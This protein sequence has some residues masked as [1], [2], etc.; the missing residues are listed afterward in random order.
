M[1]V[2]SAGKDMGKVV[3]ALQHVKARAEGVRKNLVVLVEDG[4]NNRAEL[5]QAREQLLLEVAGLR[6]EKLH[7][8]VDEMP[9]PQ[10]RRTAPAHCAAALKDAHSHTGVAQN[11]R[12]TQAGE[13]GADDGH[14]FRFFHAG[15]VNILVKGAI[16]IVL[17]AFHVDFRGTNP[18]VSQY[19]PKYSF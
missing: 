16:T 8:R 11:L 3:V 4:R 7:A 5:P 18:K 14:G 1:H 12:A 10:L 15:N 2:E 9:L 6:G 17:S 19:V 13:T